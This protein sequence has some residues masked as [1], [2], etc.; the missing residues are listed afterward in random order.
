MFINSMKNEIDLSG[1]EFYDETLSIIYS[2]EKWKVLCFEI[3]LLI[4]KEKLMKKFLS[5]L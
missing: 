5:E 3:Q 2:W 4:C 1:F